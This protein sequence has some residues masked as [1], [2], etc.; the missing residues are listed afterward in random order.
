MKTRIQYF[1]GILFL[2][3]CMGGHPQQLV[4]I[5][6]KSINAIDTLTMAF[7]GDI[8]CH[9]PQVVSAREHGHF[10]FDHWFQYVEPILSRADLAIGNLETTLA[11][12]GPFS[13]YPQFKSPDTL[14]TALKRA[15]FDVLVTSNNHS[16]DTRA[17]G[18]IHTIQSLKENGLLQT[19]TFINNF[20]KDLHYPLIIRKKDFKIALLNYT[21]DTNGIPTP[22]GVHV[23]LID[24]LQIKRD[25]QDAKRQEPDILLAFMHW[26]GEYRI[27]ADRDQ[28]RLAIKMLDL[29]VDHIIGSHPH[30]VQ[31]IEIISIDD[32]EHLV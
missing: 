3:G 30:V 15:G 19:G 5:A 16:N 20:E 8:M 29:G 22:D 27:N 9:K 12:Q 24:T 1:F 23:N 6:P 26:G 13:G 25:I 28:K 2:L 17:K 7:V 11:D 18:L 4:F 32:E 14:A 31:P 21:Y 10:D